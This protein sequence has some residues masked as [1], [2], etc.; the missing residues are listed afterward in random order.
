[1]RRSETRF[2]SKGSDV[3]RLQD[4]LHRIDTANSEDPN[5]I[6]HNGVE[7]PAELLY[8]E[9]MTRALDQ[10]RPEASEELRIA[11]RAQHLRR[12]TIP[13]GNYPMD[14][15]GYH[16]WRNDLKRKH[17]E[18]TAG[19]MS[20][21]GYEQGEIE[22]VERLIRKENLRTDPEAQVL[23]DVACLV[24]LEHYVSGFAGKHEAGKVI[25]ILRK[26]W[27][28]M[29]PEGQ[30]AAMALPLDPTVSHLLH[31]ALAAIG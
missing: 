4:V 16:R 23:E 15:A 24:F 8:S 25:S 31:E 1:V 17:A 7:R 10:F 12:W 28:K 30:R 5:R 21:A 18:W 29:S 6:V 11:V 13:R 19:L 22:H 20:E 3:N 26:T 9:R 27:S 14:R 2:A